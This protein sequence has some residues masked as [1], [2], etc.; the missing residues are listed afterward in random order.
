MTYN[1]GEYARLFKN[2]NIK[3]AFQII[4]RI[5]HR[6]KIDYYIVGGA[7]VY[8]H[9]LNPPVDY[10]DIDILLK[11]DKRGARRFALALQ[12]GGF[13]MISF[14]SPWED[15]FLRTEF[16][17][18]QF[19]IFT[20]H[21]EKYLGKPKI[22]KGLKVKPIESLV[23]EKL[24][25]SSYPDILMAIDLLASKRY[26][27]SILRRLARQYLVTGRLTILM[28]L[29]KNYASGRVSYRRIQQYA[30]KIAGT[31]RLDHS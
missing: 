25:R 30:K 21:E 24:I 29:A 31:N 12:K 22:L 2:K 13:K 20:S 27:K 10:P 11:T 26:N 28:S 3:K 19:E 16:K 6:L 7:A 23:V 15:A 4:N 14:D 5:S 18:L 1:Y 9:I 8:L 17:N